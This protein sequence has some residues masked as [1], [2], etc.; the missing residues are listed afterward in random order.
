[1][2]ADGRDTADYHVSFEGHSPDSKQPYYNTI[3]N[4]GDI[5]SA[6]CSLPDA[7][8]EELSERVGAVIDHFMSVQSALVE[9]LQ[10]FVSAY[11]TEAWPIENN[12]EL[13]ERARAALTLAGVSDE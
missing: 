1:M 2:T 4:E 6:L 10:A 11:D 13:F 3:F 12:I 8:Y 9:A 7:A 5:P